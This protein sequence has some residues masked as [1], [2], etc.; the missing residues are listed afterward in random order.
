MKPI[1]QAPA[2][3]QGYVK[4]VLTFSEYANQY[5]ELKKRE[6]DGIASGEWIDSAKKAEEAHETMMRAWR[7]LQGIEE[8]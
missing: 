6:Q 4:R 7:W 8:K 3:I 5:C 2:D 1:I